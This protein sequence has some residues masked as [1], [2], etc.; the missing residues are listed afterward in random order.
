MKRY[1]ILGIEK[2]KA[3]G[4]AY[5]NKLN[6]WFINSRHYCSN[7]G[8]FRFPL[9]IVIGNALLSFVW[10]VRFVPRSSL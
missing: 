2:G 5:L 8:Y 1:V 9:K 6:N 3:R 4:A 10:R 7:S